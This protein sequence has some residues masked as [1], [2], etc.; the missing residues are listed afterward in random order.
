MTVMSTDKAGK[1]QSLTSTSEFVVAG[2]TRNVKTAIVSGS[3]TIEVLIVDGVTYLK[4][5]A[6]KAGAKPWLKLDP[7]GKD[8][9]SALLGGVIGLIG[10]PTRLLTAGS[11]KATV[12]KIGVEGGLTHY[13]ITGIDKDQSADVWVDAQDRPA[14]LTA[15]APGKPGEAPASIEI[16]YS[17]WGAADI[18]VTA[19]PADQVGTPPAI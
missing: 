16:V 12:T 9:M 18:T 13:Q 10:D 15:T 2:S 1:P 7:N 17:D 4:D 11:D 6:P 14:K 19:P 5:P 8:F 3:G